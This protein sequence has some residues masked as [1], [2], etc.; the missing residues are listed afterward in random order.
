VDTILSALGRRIQTYDL[1]QIQL[2]GWDLF[3]ELFLARKFVHDVLAIRGAE[4]QR[5]TGELLVEDLRGRTLTDLGDEAGLR[6]ALQAIEARASQI[7]SAPGRSE[8]LLQRVSEL[9]LNQEGVLDKLLLERWAP[10]CG[11]FAAGQGK[12]KLY[13]IVDDIMRTDRGARPIVAIDLSEQSNQDIWSEELEKRILAKLLSAINARAAKTIGESANVLVVLDEAHR[14]APSGSLP[15]GSQAEALRSTLRRA[16]RETRKFGIGWFVISQTLGGI[17]GELIKQLRVLFFGFGLALGD[18]FRKLGEFAGGDRRAMELYQS[19]RD[20]HSAP[21]PDLREFP[22][23]AV[24][25]VSPLS[26][27]G[28]PVFF[29]AFTSPDEFTSLNQLSAAASR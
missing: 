9:L 21:R 2:E 15:P 22:W 3:E 6:A 20:P 10:L 14:H 28:K 29:S 18:E 27:S 19:F 24:G 11:L 25:P 16:V 26:H 8:V 1:A 7:Y 17:D 23:M 13:G 12:R 5:L 4:H